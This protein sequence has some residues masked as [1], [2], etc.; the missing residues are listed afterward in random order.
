MDISFALRHKLLLFTTVTVALGCTTAKIQAAPMSA[1]S[2]SDFYHQHYGV[3]DVNTKLVDNFG[4]GDAA[5]Y[6]VRNFRTVLFGIQYRGGANNHYLKP[7]PRSNTNPLPTVGLDNLCKEGFSKAIYLYSKNFS[8][9]PHTVKCNSIH[10]P[11]T[12]EYKQISPFT[13]QGIDQILTILHDTILN[14]QAGPVYTHCW[15]GWHASGYTSAIALRQFCGV[16]ATDAVNY[17]IRNT[18]GNVTTSELFIED[19]IKNYQPQA[20]F[21]IPTNVQREIC[22]QL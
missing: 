1:T 16:S 14:D 8:S 21:D 22:P 4:A 11:N 9:A 18:D 2:G 12:L 10:G 13:T 20:K 3:D 6:G 7:T 15:N 17:W 5:L 19:L